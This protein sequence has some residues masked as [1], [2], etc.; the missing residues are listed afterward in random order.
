MNDRSQFLESELIKLRSKIPYAKF[1]EVDKLIRKQWQSTRD[2]LEYVEPSDFVELYGTELHL[3]DGLIAAMKKQYH[4]FKPGPLEHN[5]VEL[6][7]QQKYIMTIHVT[8]E[9]PECV[10]KHVFLHKVVVTYV[11]RDMQYPDESHIFLANEGFERYMNMSSKTDIDALVY[12]TTICIN[13]IDTE[14]REWRMYICPS[15][16]C[17]E[18][19]KDD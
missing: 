13:N 2:V 7:P 12:M 14:K 8:P 16:Y 5:A 11:G 4:D 18:P 15:R 17:I 3:I 19:Y 6:I 10:H 1:K 9:W